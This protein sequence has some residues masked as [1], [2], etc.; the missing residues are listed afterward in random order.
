MKQSLGSSNRTLATAGRLAL[1]SL[2]VWSAIGGAHGQDTAQPSGWTALFDGVSLKGWR[3]T[4]FT[5]HGQVRV[6]DGMILIGKGQLT[7]ITW[8]GAFPRS[9]Y[10]IRFEATRLDGSDFFAGLT[11]PVKDSACSLISGGWGGSV[12]GL[13][14][15]DGDDASENETSTVRN[16]EKGR[17]YAFRL[18]VTENRIRVWIDADLVIDADIAGRKVGLRPGEIDLSQPLGFAAYSTVGGLRKIEYRRLGA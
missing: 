9:G 14:S 10:E 2:V 16:F 12:V 1:A 5:G 18:S 6:K 7:G 3:E 4:P 15:L 13:S 17:W 8:T 11:F